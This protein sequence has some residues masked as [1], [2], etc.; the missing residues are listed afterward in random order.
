ML[1]N[2][3]VEPL[4]TIKAESETVENA[5]REHQGKQKMQLLK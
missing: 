5:E 1:N 2:Q 4:K 3:E